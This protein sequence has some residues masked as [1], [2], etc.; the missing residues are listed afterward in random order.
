VSADT[1][2]ISP[3]YRPLS[4]LGA[5]AK[6]IDGF[7]PREQ[8]QEM[9]AAVA[10]AIARRS[11]LLCEAGTGTGKTLAYLMPALES[12]ARIIISTGTRNLQDQLFGKDLPL[13]RSVLGQ[14]VQVVLLKGRSNYLC[15]QRLQVTEGQGVTDPQLA[16][17]LR[18]VRDWASSTRLGDMSELTGVP[19]DAPVQ[20]MVTSTADNCLGQECGFW[21]ECH[22]VKAR[23]SA[24]DADIVVVNHHLFFA[25]MALRDEGVGELLPNADCVI[26]DEAHQLPEVATRFFGTSLSALQMRELA[27][28]AERAIVAAG[29]DLQAAALAARA[30]RES[31]AVT[32]IR[33]ADEVERTPW[34]QAREQPE[35]AT[36]CRRI[37]AALD[38]VVEALQPGDGGG[39]VTACMRRAIEL[40]TRLRGLLDECPDNEVRWVEVQARG[41]IWRSAPLEVDEMFANRMRAHPIA[42]IF[43]SATLAIGD[44]F[45]HFSQRMGIEADR[46]VVYP[47]P[48]DYDAQA[49]CY[50]PSGIPEP[51]DRNH[52]A[53]LVEAVLPVL[54]AS[55]GRAFLLFTSRRALR[56]AATLLRERIPFPM[57]VQGEES[58]AEL[59][60]RF[61]EHGNAILLGT[62]SFWEGVDV[63][64]EALSCVV[65]DKL[66]F[67]A[68]DDPILD[69][70]LRNMKAHGRDP[71]REHQLPQAVIALKQGAGRLIRSQTDTGVLVLGDTRIAT[72]G[73]GKSFLRSLPPMSRTRDLADV[74]AFFAETSEA[75]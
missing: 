60:R 32:R 65:I 36:A 10:E 63:R 74:A 45:S 75:L 14:P 59:T 8:Q 3:T 7:E 49:L 72:K 11:T 73:Y 28:D 56:E 25:D 69:A 16:S 2:I 33:L 20:R 66:P 62:A 31:L 27:D 37:E 1:D 71:F 68:P 61:V 39:E 53:A 48:F 44:S 47:S 41:F 13:V 50:L 22:V 35:V 4:A 15:L 21:D 34:E 18:K 12:G 58:K 38:S 43:T 23:R 30:V 42:W 26:F 19:E 24:L 52:T 17:E 29:G 40:R 51:R 67:A 55:R 70:R 9:A 6:V 64:G 46:S 5:M 54:T 57:L